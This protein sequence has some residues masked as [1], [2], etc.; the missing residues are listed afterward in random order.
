MANLLKNFDFSQP[1]ELPSLL[2][3][4]DHQGKSAAP[5]WTTWNNNAPP[6]ACAYTST[7]VVLLTN[8]D[9]LSA[10]PVPPQPICFGTH[11][12]VARVPNQEA[13]VMQVC[14]N[15]ELN[16][17]VQVFANNQNAPTH[18]RSSVWVFVLL[19]QVGMGTGHFGQTGLDVL[20]NNQ[21]NYTWQHLAAP[22]AV[23][24]ATEFIVYSAVPDGA[25]FFVAE[26]SVDLT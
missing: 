3:G 15:G 13:Q 26:A 9:R 7:E 18:T 23:S 16:G 20:S 2:I 8:V 25:W 11:D 5:S 24:P 1:P 14:T 21:L 19:G 22:N 10:T 17:I 6:G 4:I 12:F